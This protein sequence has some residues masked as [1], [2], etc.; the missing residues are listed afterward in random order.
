MTKTKEEKVGNISLSIAYGLAMKEKVSESF[1]DVLKKAEDDM[2]LHKI[3][4]SL[5]VRNGIIDALLKTLYEKDIMSEEH[6]RRVS[7][8]AF[9]L[10]K[11]ANLSEKKASD[12]KVAG[13]LHDFGKITISNHILEKKGKLTDEEFDVIKTHPEKGYKILHSIGGMDTIANYV[14]QHH[15][16]YDGFG[17]PKKLS[18][19]DISYEGKIICIA[20]AYDAMT[21]YRSYK[22]TMPDED[23]IKELIACKGTQFDPDLV[24]IFI[25]KVIRKTK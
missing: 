1:D 4:N 5:S 13:V 23:A 20:D 25:D 11:A 7:D 12:I 18:K 2:Y 22:N 6:S 9:K 14:V 3:S 17:Y 21:S 19:D 8:F 15:E 24:D 10:A 16:R